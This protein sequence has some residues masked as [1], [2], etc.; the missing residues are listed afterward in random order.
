MVNWT[1]GIVFVLQN[2]LFSSHFAILSVFPVIHSSID[3]FPL[4]YHAALIF[5]YFEF[6]P[7]LTS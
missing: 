1:P 7:I 5:L 2:Y 4:F 3:R 6:S